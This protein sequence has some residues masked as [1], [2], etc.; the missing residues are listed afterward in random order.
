MSQR[1]T[2]ILIGALA[3]GVIAAGLIFQYVGGIEDK[4]AGSAQT[5]QV[6]VAIGPIPKG[7]DPRRGHQEP[8]R[9]D[10]HRPRNHHH[11][12]DVRQPE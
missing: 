3:L 6:L 1:R 5:V 4:A 10:Q 2:L 7:S 11:L 12:V 8:D 9:G